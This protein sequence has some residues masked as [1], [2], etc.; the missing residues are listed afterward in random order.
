MSR[1]VRP[2]PNPYD[3]FLED[4]WNELSRRRQRRGG[5]G[6][7][8]S[9][10]CL[11]LG[12]PV[13]SYFAKGVYRCPFYTRRLGGTDFNC[14]VTHAENISNTFPKV[15]TTVNVY[16]CASH[17]CS[18]WRSPPGACLRSSPR[19]PRG[20]TSGGRARWECN[21]QVYM[22][23]DAYARANRGSLDLLCLYSDVQ[24][25][26]PGIRVCALL[27]RGLYAVLAFGREPRLSALGLASALTDRARAA[28]SGHGGRES[29]LSASGLA[30]ARPH[31]AMVTPP[32]CAE[33]PARPT[34]LSSSAD[35]L[36]VALIWH[37]TS[38]YSPPSRLPGRP[39]LRFR[40]LGRVLRSPPRGPVLSVGTAPSNSP[41]CHH[42]LSSRPRLFLR[43]YFPLVSILLKL[44]R[45]QLLQ[46]P[47]RRPHPSPH[48][49]R[50][51]KERKVWGGRRRPGGG[52][53]NVKR[54]IWR[55][56]VAVER[57]DV[58]RTDP[59]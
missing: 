37:S 9:P 19:L 7:Q 30:S 57:W 16:S 17:A 11:V 54:K 2:A 49:G 18:G 23:L 56:E 46:L 55:H 27:V 50:G 48:R 14:L 8:D 28:A 42:H 34:A 43:T 13:I 1:A 58:D 12:R 26:W 45:R 35:Q 15:G 53:V 3:T 10:V 31:P 25:D 59:L 29:R 20:A 41:L 32:P 22:V 24:V 39:L 6:R 51:G 52:L 33:D 21:P 5:G 44:P 36:F 47:R 38:S 4:P 40:L